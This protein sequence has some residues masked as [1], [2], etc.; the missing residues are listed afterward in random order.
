[1]PEHEAHLRVYTQRSEI[2]NED[3]SS[4]VFLEGTTD[5]LTKARYQRIITALRDGYLIRQIELAR[6]PESLE[7]EVTKAHKI[8]L[9]T[10]VE[11]VTSEVGRALT[12]LLVLQLTVKSLEPTQSIRLHKGGVNHKDFSWR[13]GISM[14]SL[15]KKFVTPALRQFELLKLNKDGFMMTRSLAE[16][17]PY[18]RF[19]KAQIKGARQ[20]WLE[21][22][23]AL[24]SNELAELPALHFL[25]RKLHNKAEAFKILAGN[26]IR[27]VEQFLRVPR[28][29]T[30]VFLLMQWHLNTVEYA[31]RIMEIQMHTLL[32]AQAELDLL[33][34][35]QLVP[36]SQMRSANKKHGNIGDIEL[37]I[38]GEIIESWDAKFGK[39]YLRDELEELND[40]LINHA[41][42]LKTGFVT[43]QIPER[44]TEL[45]SRIAELEEQ[46]D[47]KIEILTYETWIEQRLNGDE[48]TSLATRWLKAYVESLAQLR[49]QI[50][51]IDEPCGHW[52]ETLQKVL[53]KF[54]AE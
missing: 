24:E 5:A 26:V 25:L 6:V 11:A 51:P 54:N 40:K 46:H 13:E 2:I 38:A 9:E 35:A 52:L 42:V 1:M 30:Q 39:P 10:L 50:A 14:R 34:E 47:L 53:C 28:T 41:S 3:G 36:L 37:T 4:Q 15:D 44:M 22:V 32:Q 23:E 19:Y 20:Q 43:T 49:T 8:L 33:S 7:S 12:G 27:D 45:E 48:A 18:S 17:Y 16:N 29:S 21:L 31:A